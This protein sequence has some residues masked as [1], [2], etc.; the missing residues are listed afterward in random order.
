MIIDEKIKFKIENFNLYLNI[1]G[2][3][4]LFIEID[5]KYLIKSS[6]ESEI[7]FY[8]FSKIKKFTPKFFGI[9]E[10]NSIFFSLISDYVRQLKLFFKYFLLKYKL[11]ENLINIEN[12]KN[13]HS[14]FNLFIFNE[15]KKININELLPSFFS[16]EKKLLNLY[17]NNSNKFKWILFWFV[18]WNKNFLKNH[19]IIIENLTNKM[20]KPAI[21]D[22]K[23]GNSP[24][25]NKISNEI[26]IFNGAINEI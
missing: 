6:N 19:F 20:I 25:I 12:D 3:H 9:I 18:K 10:K 17:E 22:I 7:N 26:K 4:S 21:I 23:L 14:I 5:K 11:N 2:G 1:I 15:N 24:K 8:K 16:L 13:F